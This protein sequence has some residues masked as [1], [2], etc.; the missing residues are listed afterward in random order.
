M[1]YYIPKDDN[2]VLVQHLNAKELHCKCQY[3]D[4][5]R[6][7]VGE[8][9]VNSYH[10]VREHFTYPIAVNSAYR[11]QRHNADVGGK[12]GSFHMLGMALDLTPAEFSEKELDRLEFIA[13]MYYGVVIRY[14]NFIHCH[15]VR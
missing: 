3:A 8:S 5:T 2:R 6:T 9:T 12:A 10:L 4:C 15:N 7:L 11:C 13:R 1:I 14:P